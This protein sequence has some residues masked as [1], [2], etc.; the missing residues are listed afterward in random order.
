MLTARR[1]IHPEYALKYGRGLKCFEKMSQRPIWS[2]LLVKKVIVLAPPLKDKPVNGVKGVFMVLA[3]WGWTPGSICPGAT[4]QIT[5]AKAAQAWLKAKGMEHLLR[6][7]LAGGDNVYAGVHNHGGHS[8]DEVWVGRY[9]PTLSCVP[10]YACLGNHDFDHGPPGRPTCT[11]KPNAGN[12][13]QINGAVDF[14]KNERKCTA[15]RNRGPPHYGHIPDCWAMPYHSFVVRAWEES[16]GVTIVSTE[17]NSLWKGSYPFSTWSPY[18]KGQLDAMAAESK[19]V[20]R[21]AVLEEDSA[22]VLLVQNHYPW[23]YAGNSWHLYKDILEEAAKK[24]KRIYFFG[25]HTHTTHDPKTRKQFQDD[26]PVSHMIVGGA[27]GHCCCDEV[28]YGMAAVVFGM[29]KTD[30][31]LEFERVPGPGTKIPGC[32]R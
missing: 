31:T 22:K 5:V 9:G 25:G 4:C 19:T 2:F 12:C 28:K 14:V 16:L 3:D 29:I 13:G 18:L 27:G 23:D 7:V 15:G 26:Q 21:K 32:Q 20:L 24:G 11:P 6:F 8:L 1:K 10:W 30:G 17:G